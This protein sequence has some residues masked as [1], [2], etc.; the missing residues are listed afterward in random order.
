MSLWRQILP[1]SVF[2]F[3]FPFLLFHLFYLTSSCSKLLAT[4]PFPKL[5]VL[6]P[7]LCPSSNPLH[8]TPHS[9]TGIEPKYPP[10]SPSA[11]THQILQHLGASLVTHGASSGTTRGKGGK[12]LNL[13]SHTQTKA[14]SH[15]SIPFMHSSV[16]LCTQWR[17]LPGHILAAYFLG[18]YW[19]SLMISSFFITPEINSPSAILSAAETRR[20]ER[21]TRRK[22]VNEISRPG[23]PFQAPAPVWF[24]GGGHWPA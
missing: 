5:G 10:P 13:C 4:P 23:Y 24:G 1:S 11:L 7:G 9:R 8:P 17:P 15:S 19:I 12:K 20:E 16:R 6:A 2:S 3:T 21:G 14:H 18:S 22:M